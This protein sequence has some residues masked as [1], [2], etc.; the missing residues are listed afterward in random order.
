MCRIRC[1]WCKDSRQGAQ[2]TALDRWQVVAQQ[3]LHEQIRAQEGEGNSSG[4]NEALRFGVPAGH[5]GGG[6]V[7]V[8]SIDGD[9]DQM[10]DPSVFGGRCES[11]LS[12][13]LLP[14][15]STHR[16]EEYFLDAL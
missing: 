13:N 8:G 6:V 10:T 14:S 9:L 7:H 15:H 16:Q 3:V 2:E 11:H 1:E 5:R 4:F 12:S